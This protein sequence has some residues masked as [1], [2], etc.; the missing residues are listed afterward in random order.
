MK[1]GQEPR[2][3]HRNR[4]ISLVRPFGAGDT[5]FARNFRSQRRFKSY[6]R[7]ISGAGRARRR[8]CTR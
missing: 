1:S 3:Y 7:R 5:A 6:S 8:Q 4:D 2:I